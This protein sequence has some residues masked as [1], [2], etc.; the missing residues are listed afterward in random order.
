MKDRFIACPNCHTEFELSDVLTGKVDEMVAAQLGEKLADAEKRAAEKLE[1]QYAG[2]LRGLEETL[3]EQDEKIEEQRKRER[4][5]RKQKRDLEAARE[6]LDLEIERRL[7]KEREKL[8]EEAAGRLEA[9]HADRFKALQDGFEKRGAELNKLREQEVELRKERVALQEARE[10]VELEVARTLDEERA[11]IAEQAAKKVGEEHRLKD[12]E[13]D[14]KIS[15]LRV[16]LEDMKRKAEQGSMETQGEVLEL[17]FEEKLKHFFLHDEIKPVPRG[18][19]GA[20][21]VQTVRAANGDECG[22]LLW[23]TKNTKA[24]SP[25][26]IPKLKAD[27]VEIR[28]GLAILTSVVLPAEIERFGSMGGVWVSDPE[29]AIPLAAALREQ[30]IA[31]ER[32]RIASKGKDEKTEMLY[33]YLSG[34]EFRQKIEGIVEAFR[35]MQDQINQERRVMEKHWRKRQKQVDVVVKNTA[36]LYG[37]MQGIIGSDVQTIPALELESCD[38]EV[39]EL[40]LGA[41]P[42][43]LIH[44]APK[45]ADPIEGAVRTIATRR[46][47]VRKERPPKLENE[48]ETLD[49]VYRLIRELEEWL[50]K[51]RFTHHELEQHIEPDIRDEIIVNAKRARAILTGAIAGLLTQG[52]MIHREDGRYEL[53]D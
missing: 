32:E 50:S 3:K 44:E 20:D 4:E 42:A 9:K 13:K 48:A 39:E 22:I 16:A 15:D 51:K 34:N 1:R 46:K 49:L 47:A 6:E 8:L 33:R 31:V 53:V 12:L 38:R 11:K 17:D 14:K 19:R 36:G 43:A 21:L 24:W 30:L 27:M 7:E 52:R 25:Q 40:P 41:S 28:A 35:S 45:E 37:D 5:L 2:K 10:K 23:E 29:S 18:I 26:W